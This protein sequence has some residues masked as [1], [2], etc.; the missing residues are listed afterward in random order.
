MR[1][2]EGAQSVGRERYKDT[3]G[4]SKVVV[5]VLQSLQS[6]LLNDPDRPGLCLLYDAFSVMPNVTV[7]RV[8]DS[9][10]LEQLVT[11]WRAVAGL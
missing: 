4:L 7:V 6:S 2:V 10:L 11:H 1:R 8:V 9:Q 3:T 5:G